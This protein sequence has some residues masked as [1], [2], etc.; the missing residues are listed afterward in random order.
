VIAGFFLTVRNWLYLTSVI[1]LV[2]VLYGY[3]FSWMNM[4]HVG[5]TIVVVSN[6]SMLVVGLAYLISLPFKESLHHGL[7]HLI[8]FY[9]FYYWSTRW[10]KMRRPV[11]NTIGSFLPIALVVLGYAIYKEKDQIERAVENPGEI[12]ER[13][14]ET[15][16]NP[17]E[18][19]KRIRETVENPGEIRKR[20]ENERD[21]LI[22]NSEPDSLAP[23]SDDQSP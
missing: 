14:R 3:L 6:I 15:V 13:I 20:V 9:A 7:A 19:R 16:E 11:Y 8:P 22:K 10:H 17:G 5:A 1:G 4:L 2:I 12:E 18:I 21:E 23:K